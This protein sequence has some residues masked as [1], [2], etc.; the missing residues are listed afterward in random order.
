[1]FTSAA[2]VGRTAYIAPARSAMAA[3][4]WHPSTDRSLPSADRVCHESNRTSS[5]SPLTRWPEREERPELYKFSSI[6]RR[7]DPRA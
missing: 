4:V 5:T 6:R 1:M 7:A 3:R 2:R